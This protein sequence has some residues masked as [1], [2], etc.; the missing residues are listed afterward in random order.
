M[1]SCFFSSLLKMRISFISESRNL[2]RTALP[3][4]PVPPV[5]KSIL[6]L[7]N[8]FIIIIIINYILSLFF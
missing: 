3:N 6:S 4:E 1:S 8:L 5:I 2:S 7:N